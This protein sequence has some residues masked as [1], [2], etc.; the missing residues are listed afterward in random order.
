MLNYFHYHLFFIYFDIEKRWFLRI[1]FVWTIW[2]N[3]IE[4][5]TV[6]FNY[7]LMLVIR[8]W[9]CERFE[10]D[11]EVVWRRNLYGRSN[12]QEF[13][14]L[15]RRVIPHDV[16]DDDGRTPK[17]IR[18]IWQSATLCHIKKASTSLTAGSYFSVSVFQW[19]GLSFFAASAAG[20]HSSG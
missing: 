16:N 7:K 12:L 18:V 1:G 4:T 2:S 9:G 11:G 17:K 15:P 5:T 8:E 3:I 10:S 20:K 13:P 19:P 14:I 6:T